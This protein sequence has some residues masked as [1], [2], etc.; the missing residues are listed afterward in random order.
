[1]NTSI[2]Q[3][4]FS[5]ASAKKSVT[6]LCPCFIHRCTSIGAGAISKP[7]FQRSRYEKGS[8]ILHP[9]GLLRSHRPARFGPHF[10][11]ETGVRYHPVA[12]RS[13]YLRESFIF[14]KLRFCVKLYLTYLLQGKNVRAD[15]SAQKA[16]RLLSFVLH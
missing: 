10:S 15:E 9:I 6:R 8:Q 3:A 11:G 16:E 13:S 2:C 1:M 4:F 14:T 7:S 5:G 12:I